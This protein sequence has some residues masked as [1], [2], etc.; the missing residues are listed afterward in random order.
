MFSI[1]RRVELVRA[2]RIAL[3]EGM[4]PEEVRTTV[5]VVLQSTSD[6]RHRARRVAVEAIL[7]RAR[8]YHA[9]PGRGRPATFDP[10]GI[11]EAVIDD[12]FPPDRY[13]RKQ[14]IDNYLVDFCGLTP[15]TARRFREAVFPEGLRPLERFDEGHF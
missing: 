2:T 15:A 8:D 7:A 9:I 13:R 14:D 10:V 6:S 5:A 11:A 4:S 3:A 12:C 1:A